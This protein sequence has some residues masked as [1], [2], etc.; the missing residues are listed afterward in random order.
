MHGAEGHARLSGQ[1]ARCLRAP[2]GEAGWSEHGSP[3]ISSAQTHTANKLV[4][5]T[6]LPAP[7]TTSLNVCVCVCVPPKCQPLILRC[8]RNSPAHEIAQYMDRCMRANLCWNSKCP[9]G[10]VQV[11]QESSSP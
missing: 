9:G 8:Q 6:Q 11:V 5:Q 10:N 4:E 2:A 3:Q 1:P 7:D